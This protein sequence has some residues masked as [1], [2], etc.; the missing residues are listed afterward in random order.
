MRSYSS[1]IETDSVNLLHYEYRKLIVK[2]EILL[3]WVDE[4][5]VIATIARVIYYR[6]DDSDFIK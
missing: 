2:N 5:S 6:C 3:Y 4:K 1:F